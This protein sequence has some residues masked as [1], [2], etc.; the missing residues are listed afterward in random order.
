M[1]Y[2]KPPL[3]KTLLDAFEIRTM[4][5]D[6]IFCRLWF[7]MISAAEFWVSHRKLEIQ[8]FQVTKVELD[9]ETQRES[10]RFCWKIAWIATRFLLPGSHLFPLCF[11]WV[12]GELSK[13]IQHQWYSLNEKC[14]CFTVSPKKHW[15][16]A[17]PSWYD[18]QSAKGLANLLHKCAVGKRVGRQVQRGPFLPLF[19]T[20]D[21]YIY[22]SY[23][24]LDGR[25]KKMGKL[26]KT[27]RCDWWNFYL[28]NHEDT[29]KW[30]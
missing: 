8:T 21:I 2:G 4:R 23:I 5:S 10:D 28:M 19:A 22:I 11:C 9:I 24:C 6:W 17:K 12:R 30:L 16:P 29:K 1:L 7:F 14:F 3:P 13:S 25:R 20:G 27:C 18:R 15:C 26:R